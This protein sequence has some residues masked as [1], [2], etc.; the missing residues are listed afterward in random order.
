MTVRIVSNEA[1]F[2]RALNAHLAGNLEDAASFLKDEIVTEIGIQGPP[3]SQPG[4]PPHVDTGELIKS[5]DYDVDAVSLTAR[6]GSDSPYVLPLERG[7]GRMA[8]RPHIQATLIKNSD[9]VGRRMC[10]P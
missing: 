2:R 7:T 9:E 4:E 10:K 1:A 5:F 3:R 8:A 6:V